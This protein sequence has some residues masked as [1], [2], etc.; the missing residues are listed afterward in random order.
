MKTLFPIVCAMVSLSGC[1]VGYRHQWG[2]DHLSKPALSADVTHSA[3][4]FYAGVVID[5]RYVR[6][7]SPQEEFDHKE[8]FVDSD[9]GRGASDGRQTRRVLR[10]DVPA[11]SVWTPSSGVDLRYPASMKMRKSLDLILG[12]D[13]DL[14]GA[15]T[16]RLDAGIA[17]QHAP[18]AA[19]KVLGG[20]QWTDY[21]GSTRA[22]DAPLRS[23]WEG[24]SQ[25]PQVGAELT[26]FA[27]EY[28]LK[29]FEWL[30][31]K[32]EKHRERYGD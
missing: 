11:L 27:G 21:R 25:G 12:G 4:V 17:Y 30:L 20:W 19:G 6:L 32:D 15:R 5:L 9:G 16:L 3:H 13:V 24:T 7:L 22:I 8:T 28:A 18:W 2:D 23:I 29:V 26:L 10:L 1:A 14:Q 31:K